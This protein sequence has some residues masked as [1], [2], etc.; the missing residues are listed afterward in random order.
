MIGEV[1]SCYCAKV[2]EIGFEFY[3]RGTVQYSMIY[4]GFS[5]LMK[6]TASHFSYGFRVRIITK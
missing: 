3:I 2:F 4:I 5:K 6:P 1:F